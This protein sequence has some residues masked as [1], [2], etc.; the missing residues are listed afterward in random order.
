MNKDYQQ[1]K[2]D[3]KDVKET[4]QRS[5]EQAKEQ[6]RNIGQSSN[7]YGG[8]LNKDKS[9]NLGTN[10]DKGVWDKTKEFVGQA[11]DTVVEGVSGAYEKTK[12]L[13]TGDNNDNV[14]QANRDINLNKDK[15]F[16][17]RK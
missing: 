7:Q 9:A 1:G 11:K 8:D 10:Q 2:H 15:N 6:A 17:D 16:G 12:D 13:I 14:K 3:V 5:M 4:A